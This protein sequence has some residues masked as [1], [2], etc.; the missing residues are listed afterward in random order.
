MIFAVNTTTGLAH[1]EMSEEG[2]TALRLNEFLQTVCQQYNG[3]GQCFL[4]IDNAPAHQQAQNLQLPPNFFVRYLPPYSPFSN[5]CE[6]AF[7][8]WKGAI[9]DQLAEVR[10]QL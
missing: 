3:D 10:P 1:H 6:D 7:S 2:V 9:K 8:L 4:L 5:I